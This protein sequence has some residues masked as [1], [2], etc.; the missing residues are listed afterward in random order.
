MR[1]TVFTPTYNRAYTLPKLYDSL[2][3]QTFHDFEWIVIDDGS[4]DD[5]EDLFKKIIAEN[6]FFPVIYKKTENGGKHRA[7]NRGI[8]LANGEMT[9]IMDSDDWLRED[10]LELIDKYEKEIPENDK[11]KYAGVQGLRVYPSGE[12]IGRTFEGDGY[13]DCLATER[14]KYNIIGDKCEVY[15]TK[16]LKE[17]P[18]PEFEGEK[19]V[20]ERLVWNVFAHN[21]RKIRYFNEGIYFCDYLEDG[22]THEGYHLY[23]RNPKQ[24][25]AAIHQD[26][27]FGVA[28]FY[29]TTIQIY[30]YYLYEKGLISKKDMIKNLGFSSVHFYFSVYL[31]KIIDAVRFILHKKVTV[32]GTAEN[33][34]GNNRK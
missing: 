13:C 2:K 11:D 30:I 6:P 22:L 12:I 32:K 8:H 19:F 26:Y 25:A 10:A 24:W 33:D 18:F 27:D 7:I 20:T 15:Y 28:D 14:V 3:K 21:G 9:V 23:A 34:I 1:I 31:Q 5:T 17:T 4:T 29:N 16:L